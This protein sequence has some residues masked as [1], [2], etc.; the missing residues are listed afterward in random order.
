M[1]LDKKIKITTIIRTIAFLLACIY[2]VLW[3][4]DCFAP[5]IFAKFNPIFSFLPSIF[6]KIIKS[7]A[8]FFD[9]QVPMG[10]V[11]SALTCI[12]AQ[13]I[14][15]KKIA[16]FEVQKK[17]QEEQERNRKFIVEARAKK[18]KEEEKLRSAKYKEM[19]FGLLEFNLVYI[20]SYGK[21]PTELDK[22]KLKYYKMLVD[23]LKL[24]YSQINFQDT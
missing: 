23:K 12:L 9:R 4:C 2:F 21:D 13:Y 20:D 3:L 19:F 24:K 8:T 7:T 6:N 11:W 5:A 15:K 14:C 10:Y 17:V 22:L 1:E 18:I 16:S